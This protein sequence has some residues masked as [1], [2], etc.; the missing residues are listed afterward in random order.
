MGRGARA[1]MKNKHG[2]RESERRKGG[3]ELA[4][5]R[6]EYARVEDHV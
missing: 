2:G 6:R 4:R 3:K 5:G 1:T